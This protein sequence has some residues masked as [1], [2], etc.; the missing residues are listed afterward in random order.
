MLPAVP[1]GLGTLVD[2]GGGGRPDPPAAVPPDPPCPVAPPRLL[3]KSTAEMDATFVWK[4]WLP[5]PRLI[6][7]PIGTLP[8]AFRTLIVA[9]G[10]VLVTLAVVD[11]GIGG[12]IYTFLP[13]PYTEQDI[14]R[15]LRS[16]LLSS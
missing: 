3:L 16:V 13:K 12:T 11:L 14:E 5:P 2:P 7:V 10:F 15:L 9:C 8:L 6:I 1:L 4:E